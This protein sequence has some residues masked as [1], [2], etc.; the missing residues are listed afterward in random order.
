MKTGGRWSESHSGGPSPQGDARRGAGHGGWEGRLQAETACS[1]VFGSE[2]LSLIRRGEGPGFMHHTQ[3]WA[4]ETLKRKI[5][6]FGELKKKKKENRIVEKIEEKREVFIVD[7][8]ENS[9]R[10]DGPR[11][12]PTKW[13]ESDRGR[14]TSQDNTHMWNLRITQM[15]SFTKQRQTQTQKTDLCS[16]KG[17]GMGKD[18]LGAGVNSRYILLYIK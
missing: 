8:T 14:Q 15:N 13:G 3:P 16:P 12:Y 6:P 5:I 10:V 1:P 17:K 18:K 9:S 2:S 7:K 11:D 4:R